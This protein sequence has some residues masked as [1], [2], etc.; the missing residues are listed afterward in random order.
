[1]HDINLRRKILSEYLD[2]K[3]GGATKKQASVML[4]KKYKVPAL[5]ICGWVGRSEDFKRMTYNAGSEKAPHST[6]HDAS[7]RDENIRLKK[8]IALLIGS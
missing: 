8:V 2:A 4:G 1:M 5:T 7:L 6:D 3:N